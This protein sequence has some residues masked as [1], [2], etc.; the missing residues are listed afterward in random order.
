[1]ATL[2]LAG[3]RVLDLSTV[4]AAPVT[5]TFLGDFGAEV[6]KVEEPGRGDFTRGTASGGRSPT[7]RRR[8]ATRSP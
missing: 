2:P 4:L 3:I 8:R 5:A 1:M 7:G 6:I